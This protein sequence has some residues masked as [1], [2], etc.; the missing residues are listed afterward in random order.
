MAG[1][2]EG[3]LL[4]QAEPFNADAGIRQGCPLSPY[5]FILVMTVLFTDA[6][7][8]IQYNLQDMPTHAA[9]HM[10]YCTQTTP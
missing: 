7:E 2:T 3:P 5:L 6:Y 4:W 8:G 10:I 9:T 1:P